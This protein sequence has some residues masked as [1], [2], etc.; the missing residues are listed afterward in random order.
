MNFTEGKKKRHKMANNQPRLVVFSSCF[1]GVLSLKES[2]LV[3]PTGR[4]VWTP[5][6][7]CS[8][9]TFRVQAWLCCPYHSPPDRPPALNAAPS[10]PSTLP[11][12]LIFDNTLIFHTYI[13]S[14]SDLTHLSF[15]C[16]VTF[17][18]KLFL[19]EM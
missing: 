10:Q 13:K 19:P 18:R 3:S 2:A 1:C 9:L 11:A 4:T 5:L 14:I 12:P 15:F 16:S 17:L 6:L 7:Y 8:W